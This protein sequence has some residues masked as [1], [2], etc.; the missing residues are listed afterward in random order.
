MRKP[1]T[2][3][4]TALTRSQ[5][6]E[7]RHRCR[8]ERQGGRLVSKG[9]ARTGRLLA[10]I[11][12]MLAVATDESGKRCRR[13]SN[14]HGIAGVTEPCPVDAVV[15]AEPTIVAVRVRPP[16]GVA[17]ARRPEVVVSHTAQ[18]K[19]PAA[20]ASRRELVGGDKRLGFATRR[21]YLAACS[22]PRSRSA[23]SESAG[24][25]SSST[26]VSSGSSNTNGVDRGER[27]CRARRSAAYRG[28]RALPRAASV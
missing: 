12:L 7:Q 25:A 17:T 16:F 9:A 4:S 26:L 13:L 1:A 23:R 8:G 20:E 3:Q 19:R 18:E 27:P 28:E 24:R 21:V 6:T 2:A 11:Q 14:S 5:L 22:S 15:S 10:R